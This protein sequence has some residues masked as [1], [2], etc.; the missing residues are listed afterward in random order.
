MRPINNYTVTK[1]ATNLDVYVNRI[2]MQHKAAGIT[3]TLT[4]E[5]GTYV[6]GGQLVLQG[7]DYDAWGTDDN[8]IWNWT[9]SQLGVTIK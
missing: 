3:W 7:A 6:D 1:T 9:A 4:S 2:E 5:D 8:Y